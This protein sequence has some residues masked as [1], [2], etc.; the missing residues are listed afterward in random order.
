MSMC[1]EARQKRNFIATL[2]LSL[3]VPMLLAGDEFGRRRQ[4]NNNAYCQDNEI[5]WLDWRAI[6]EQA[7]RL[8]L[9]DHQVPKA[10]SSISTA[11]MV[12]GE[13]DSRQ[14]RQRKS[15][16]FRPDWRTDVR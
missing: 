4:G 3:G 6:D 9:T 11:K 10:A 15:A 12:R 13:I 8:H 16:W 2:F 7:A 5:S 14:R 1:C